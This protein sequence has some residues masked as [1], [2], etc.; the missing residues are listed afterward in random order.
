VSGSPLAGGRRVCRPQL[1][2]GEWQ[3]CHPRPQGRRVGHLR[4][5]GSTC[6]LLQLLG[7]PSRPPTTAVEAGGCAPVA[8]RARARCCLTRPSP[9]AADEM[10]SGAR[11]CGTWQ[12]VVG[13]RYG[14]A[15]TPKGPRT[16]AAGR[17]RPEGHQSPAGVGGAPQERVA[18]AAYLPHNFAYL[19]AACSGSASPI[20]ARA[21][22][23][24]DT[25]DCGGWRREQPSRVGCLPAPP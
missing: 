1:W 11:R 25:P 3:L 17:G 24:P 13:A 18:L 9:T 21:K 19:P 12:T 20:V 16:G 8:A 5:S 23:S 4:R 10:L 14:R 2:Q 15:P 7:R 6:Q 22:R